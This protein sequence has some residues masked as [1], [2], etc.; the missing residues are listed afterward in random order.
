M[1]LKFGKAKQPADRK[2]PPPKKKPYPAKGEEKYYVPLHNTPTC[3]YTGKK[4]GRKSKEEKEKNNVE[5]IKKTGNFVLD[6][7]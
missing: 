5:Y 7:D 6:F 4:R 3:T 2:R 1:L